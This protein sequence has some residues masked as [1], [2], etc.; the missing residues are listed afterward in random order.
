M[1]VNEIPKVSV[2]IPTFNQERLIARAIESAQRQ[3]YPNLEIIISDDCSTDDTYEVVKKYLADHR[4][5][6]FRNEVNLGRVANY[7]KTLYERVSGE[8]AL[9]LDGDDYFFAADALSHMMSEIMGRE[10]SNL[11]AA[12]GSYMPIFKGSVPA[13]R[14]LKSCESRLFPGIDIFL[15]W[16]K[17]NFGHLATLYKVQMAKSIDYYRL[18]TISSD[19]ES[20][21]R[22]LLHGNVLITKKIIAVW[23]IHDR[24]ATMTKTIA[25]GILDFNYIESAFQY[26]VKLGINERILRRWY[27]K[28]I[29]FHTTTLWTSNVRLSIKV[30]QFLPYVLTTYPFA[31]SALLSPKVNFKLALAR[32]PALFFR[33]RAAYHRTGAR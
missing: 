10:N 4:V 28:M 9:N 18:N 30:R 7:K 23:S 26:A 20:V 6:Y 19:W 3:D 17:R 27:R 22:L 32:H 25:E 33:I 21:L 15:N 29:R 1:N 24:N 11:V 5:V 8:W 13:R 16:D 14:V 2:M 12:I 31:L